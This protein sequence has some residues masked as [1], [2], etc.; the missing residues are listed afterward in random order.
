MD[1]YFR[2]MQ[3]RRDQSG[4]FYSETPIELSGTAIM[5]QAH[6]TTHDYLIQAVKDINEVM[7]EGAAEKYPQIV[8]AYLTVAATDYGATIIA[9]QVRLGLDAITDELNSIAVYYHNKDIDE[10]EQR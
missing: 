10:S 8:A 6:M 3:H 2:E 5:H 1:D 4:A 9:Q 7:G